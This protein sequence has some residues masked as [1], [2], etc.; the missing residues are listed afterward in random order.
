MRAQFTSWKVICSQLSK[1]INKVQYQHKLQYMCR[2]TGDIYIYII[3]NT[4]TTLRTYVFVT[5]WLCCLWLHA[6]RSM[7][8]VV[9]FYT[10]MQGVSIS[11]SSTGDFLPVLH[12]DSFQYDIYAEFFWFQCSVQIVTSLCFTHIPQRGLYT[13]QKSQKFKYKRGLYCSYS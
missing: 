13:S 8:S 5:L 11:N 3:H 7:I 1:R 10:S 4:M 2:H 9:L 6:R 12:A